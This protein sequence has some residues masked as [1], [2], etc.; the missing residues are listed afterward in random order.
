MPIKL[1]NVSNVHLD[2]AEHGNEVVF[3]YS[4]QSGPANQ[5][6]GLQVAR[7]AGVP[8]KVIE[9]SRSR[10][11]EL[12][13]QYAGKME[14]TTRNDFSQSTLFAESH[15]E[16]QAVIARLGTVFPDK[17]SP[18]EALDLLYELNQLLAG[19]LTDKH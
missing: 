12:E 10:L 19:H 11:K 3:L 15:P 1:D 6:Y 2:A 9:M 14:I 8:N 17:T 7:L 4:V 13:K 18:R 5:S 16:E